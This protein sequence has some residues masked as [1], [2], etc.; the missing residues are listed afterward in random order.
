MLL[1][2]Q[3]NRPLTALNR[4][5]VPPPQDFGPGPGFSVEKRTF[6]ARPDDPDVKK[7]LDNDLGQQRTLL[8]EYVRRAASAGVKRGGMNVAGSPALDSTLRGD[9]MR[10]LAAGTSQAFRNAMDY[11]KYQAATR[12]KQFQDRLNNLRQMAEDRRKDLQ[13]LLD[14]AITVN[15]TSGANSAAASNGAAG[16]EAQSHRFGGVFS[17]GRSAVAEPVNTGRS[18]AAYASLDTAASQRLKARESELKQKQM[19]QDLETAKRKA[20]M[21]DWR[22]YVEKRKEQERQSDL[23]KWDKLSSKAGLTSTLG[24]QGAGWTAQDD[25]SAEYLGVKLGYLK[26]WNRSMTRKSF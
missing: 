5:L 6:V 7:Y 25:S 20:E 13:A 21:D 19:Q 3:R 26:P 18:T 4:L 24:K 1:Q 14:G 22:N 10:T 23:A 16:T 12:Y 8:D 9:S 15:A 2:L 11:G 17:L